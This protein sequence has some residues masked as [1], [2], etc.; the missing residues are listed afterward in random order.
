MSDGY[1]VETLPHGIAIYGPV[2]LSQTT[3]VAALGKANGY[4][5]MDLGIASTLRATF[6]LTSREHGEAWR[7][8]I[9]QKLLATYPDDPLER[10]MRGIDTGTSSWTMLITL[11]PDL[12]HRWRTDRTGVPHDADDVGRCIRLLRL[13]PTLAARRA[14]VAAVPGWKRLIESWDELEALYD[15]AEERGEGRGRREARKVLSDRV[16]S[17]TR[18]P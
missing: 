8:E 6:V 16:A 1:R 11:R 7:T 12:I 15:A 17:L 2:P 4:D 10:W 13:V 3:A 18:E 5:L 14:E 9:E